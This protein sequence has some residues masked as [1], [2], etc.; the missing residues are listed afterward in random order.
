MKHIS[1]LRQG[2]FRQDPTRVCLQRF[3]LSGE[4]VPKVSCVYRTSDGELSQVSY[5]EGGD[6]GPFYTIERAYRPI[7]VSRILHTNLFGYHRED[8]PAYIRWD[9]DGNVVD[10][11]WA[12]NGRVLDRGDGT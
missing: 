6:S 5:N 3:Y 12:R 2:F 9:R 7:R 1:T 4:H 11:R 8:G 10:V